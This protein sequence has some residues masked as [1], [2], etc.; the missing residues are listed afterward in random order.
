MSPA[1]L[2]GKGAEL[3]AKIPAELLPAV[4]DVLNALLAGRPDKAERLAKDAA[5]AIAARKA[6]S[7][8]IKATK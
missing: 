1:A 7:A 2:L 5:L 3:L 8:R 4:I 6:A